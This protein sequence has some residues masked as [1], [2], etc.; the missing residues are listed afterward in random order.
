MKQEKLLRVIIQSVCIYF[1]GLVVIMISN[2]LVIGLYGN[3]A[4][5]PSYYEFTNGNNTVVIEEKSFLL[6]GEGSIN[7]VFEDKSAIELARFS[8]DDGGRNNGEYDV[9]WKGES[10]EITYKTFTGN[11]DKNAIKVLLR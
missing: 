2:I 11:N 3:E 1:V 10:V 4:Y 8:T 7:Q 6:Y 9:L 5:D